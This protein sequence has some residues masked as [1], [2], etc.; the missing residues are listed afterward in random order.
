MNAKSHGAIALAIVVALAC[1]ALS[2]H[3]VSAYER[4]TRWTTGTPTR[5]FDDRLYNP[6]SCA[7]RCRDAGRGCVAWNYEAPPPAVAVGGTSR[8]TLLGFPWQGPRSPA[9]RFASGIAEEAMAGESNGQ[10]LGPTTPLDRVVTLTF[11]NPGLCARECS[12]DARCRRW[13]YVRL[14]PLSPPHGGMLPS[15]TCVL[16]YANAAPPTAPGN[17]ITATTR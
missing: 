7:R 14:L 6:E 3:A 2:V 5:T 9:R 11:P 15:L 16:S 4:S 10:C 12:A 13:S 8:C 17:C 1:A